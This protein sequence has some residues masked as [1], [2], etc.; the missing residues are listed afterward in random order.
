MAA[1]MVHGFLLLWDEGERIS[2]LGQVVCLGY[3]ALGAIL[4]HLVVMG[5]PFLR[6]LW[7]PL[8]LVRRQE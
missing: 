2:V 3:S 7:T 8:V 5:L 4:L 6:I 1:G